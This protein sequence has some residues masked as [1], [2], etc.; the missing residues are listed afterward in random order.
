MADIFDV[1][2]WFLSKAPMT[3]KKLQKLC[4]YYKAWGLALYDRDLL[5]QSEFQAWVHGPVNPQLYAKYK[6]YGWNDIPQAEDNS[7]LFSEKEID[8]LESVWMTY[9]NMSANAL[10]AQTHTEEP[11]RKARRGAPDFQNC[12]VVIDH[13]AMKE[14]YRRVYQEEQGE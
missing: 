12:V 9:G 2:T 6:D 3:P 11:W 13:E 8:L 1:A 4:Y 14:Y 5:P 10:E 7:K